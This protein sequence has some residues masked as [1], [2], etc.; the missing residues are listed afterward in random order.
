MDQRLPVRDPPFVPRL[1]PSEHPPQRNNGD[2]RP[3]THRDEVEVPRLQCLPCPSVHSGGF[4]QCLDP[5][6]L[7]TPTSTLSRRTEE[8][9]ESGGPTRDVLQKRKS[10]KVFEETQKMN[11]RRGSQGVPGT[12]SIKKW[13]KDLL[14]R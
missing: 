14:N 5:V 12:E 1:F 2:V 7:P 9:T 8:G 10:E 3:E 6:P 4:R 11:R 13:E